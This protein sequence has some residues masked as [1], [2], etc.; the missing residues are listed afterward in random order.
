LAAGCLSSGAAVRADA[1]TAYA[2]TSSNQIVVFDTAAPA[3]VSTP[4]T[5]TGLQAAEALLAIDIR[6]ATGQLYALGSS[7]RL[8]V[9]DVT[10]GAARQIGGGTFATGL[11]GSSFGFDF[12]PTVDR[13]RVVSDN[14]QNLRLH[15]DTG[16]LVQV[17][18]D[19]GT[20]GDVVGSAYTN[21]YSGALVTTLYGID[22]AADQLVRQGGINGAPSP[23]AGAITPIGPLG[24]DTTS[25]LGFD[26]TANDG[27][28]HAALTVGGASSLYTIN[29][30]SG[31]ATLVGA[32]G[33][34]L[35]VRGLAV[36]SR[37][38]TLYG[39]TTSN[40]LVRF[41][42]ATPGT[43]IS[44]TAIS[45]LQAGENVLGID[46]RPANGQL[47]AVGSTSRLYRVDTATGL[48]TQVGTAPFAPPLSGTELGVDFNPTVDRLRVVSDAGQ[49]IRLNPDTGM[50]AGV[51]TNLTGGVLVGSAYTNNVDGAAT[52]TLYGIDATAA[53]D[54]LLR[55]GGINGVPSPNGGVLT[56]VGPLGA[57][58]SGLVGFDISPL[59]GTAFASLTA[60]AVSSLYT[61]SL[62]NGAATLITPIGGTGTIRALA[63]QPTT[64]NLAEGSTGDFFDTDILLLNPNATATPATI[65]YLREDGATFTQGLTLAPNSRS[66]VTVDSVPG[67]Q[68]TAFSS[69][70]SSPLPIVVERTMRWDP[71]GYG[72]HTEKAAE[73]LSRTW[74]FAEGSQGF[75]ET[76]ILLA[77]PAP[78]P[79]TASVEFLLEGGGA[80]PKSYTVP[81]RSRLTIYAGGIPELVNRSFATTVRFSIAAAAERAMYFGTPVFNAGHESAGAPSPSTSWFLAEGAIG[82]F[83]TTFLLLANPGDA[84]ANVTVN[85]LVEGGGLLTK[86]KSMPPRSRLTV[87]IALEDPALAA[88]AVATQVISDVP[89]VAER[90]QYWPFTPDQWYEAHNSFGVTRTSAR[91]GLAEG[92]VG[93]A[94]ANQTFILLANQGSTVANVTL[95]FMR[96]TGDPVTKTALVP[97]N[98]RLTVAS[99][100]GNF[101]PELADENFGTLIVSDRPI[102]VER[103]FYSNANGVF[104]A[105]G[106]DAMATALP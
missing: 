51:D 83:F 74:Y 24:V 50:V 1:S 44:A 11:N 100:P 39:V 9:I 10:T 49:N 6:P 48:A 96:Q 33:T 75:F 32:I 98:G 14:G 70:V 91:W 92:R 28:A 38:V 46:F 77:N 7:T 29:L 45:G 36:L 17:D 54:Q 73:A 61:V 2:L 94:S 86:Q 80:V 56:P 27:V 71:S 93:T 89:V 40:Q 31:A 43:I 18:T 21:N 102:F 99:G 81:P 5:V 30:G 105:A 53:P 85:Y 34:G 60:G 65:T 88:T 42:S 101:M 67:V 55:Q 47:Y 41:N 52:T 64:F 26:I 23:N 35:Q 22:S 37:A 25:P 59:D 13:I 76:F 68:A 104:L 78:V 12:N 69:V 15:P 16:A 87:N 103:A 4:I 8:Y 19:L 3:T 20:T 82:R 106:S 95:T 58:S 57:D 66:T 79:T 97:A 62:T 72:S 63:A 90:A 84:P